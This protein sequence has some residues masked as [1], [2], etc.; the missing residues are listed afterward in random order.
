MKI[1]EGNKETLLQVS[2]E[3]AEAELDELRIRAVVDAQQVE[4]SK[5]LVDLQKELGIS[6]V[7]TFIPF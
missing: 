3:Q 2:K 1:T 6:T 7:F 4:L 5:F